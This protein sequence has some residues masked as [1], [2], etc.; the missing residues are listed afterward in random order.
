M[1]EKEKL[2]SEVLA[3]KD[4]IF[5]RKK[6]DSGDV[7]GSGPSV[8][9]SPST[10]VKTSS[11]SQSKQAQKSGS[12]F[13]ISNFEFPDSAQQTADRHHHY[14]FLKVKFVG[15]IENFPSSDASIL[16]NLAPLNIKF[17][18][19]VQ[20]PVEIKK[21]GGKNKKN[22][23]QKNQKLTHEPKLVERRLSI[24]MHQQPNLE[25][26]MFGAISYSK[27]KSDHFN[28]TLKQSRLGMH[29]SNIFTFFGEFNEHGI[30][31]AETVHLGNNSRIMENGSVNW[32]MLKM[33]Q[34]HNYE[35]I[36][37]EL[38]HVENV[39]EINGK[40]LSLISDSSAE[41]ESE[42]SEPETENFKKYQILCKLN[43]PYLFE[44]SSRIDLEVGQDV[45]LK[46]SH[47]ES[48]AVC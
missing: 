35:E 1:S 37:K 29:N 18:Q 9:V 33:N 24:Q 8:A 15:F 27:L 39:I 30:F 10:S 34:K 19:Q 6:L 40:V 5:I 21:K 28:R 17:Y 11:S 7:A 3:G 20:V 26:E 45:R 44:Y 22:N 4:K 14:E 42:N 46:G 13:D 47:L 12:A 48:L 43:Q 2:I 41:G 36:A 23:A 32:Q 38:D 31:I 16:P 25:D